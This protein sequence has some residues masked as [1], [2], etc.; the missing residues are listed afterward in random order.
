M[1]SSNRELVERGKK[2][3][4]RSLTSASNI[5]EVKEGIDKFRKTHEG[6]VGSTEN[7]G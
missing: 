4:K 1:S 7:E 3:L 2:N 6:S 5:S